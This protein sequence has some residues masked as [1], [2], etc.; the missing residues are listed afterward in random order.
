MLGLFDVGGGLAVLL[1]LRMHR[2]QL[3]QML[4]DI[5]RL[6]QQTDIAMCTAA[7]IEAD[8]TSTFFLPILTP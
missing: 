5:G 4:Q 1:Q 6:M 3:Q 8:G 7:E 2:Q